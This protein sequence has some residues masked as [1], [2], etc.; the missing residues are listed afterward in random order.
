MFNNNIHRI[1]VYIR[2]LKKKIS[3]EEVE[4]T[5]KRMLEEIDTKKCLNFSI[6]RSRDTTQL[7]NF[8]R[9]FSLH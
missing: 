5:E 7:I 2:H 6:G 9:S 1:T 4:N 8:K 3:L